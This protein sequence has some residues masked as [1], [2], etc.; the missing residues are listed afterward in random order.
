MSTVMK[1][2][3]ILA[4]KGPAVVTVKPTETI[5]ALSQRLREKRIGAAVV[6]S[7]GRVFE[8]VISERDI[9]YAVSAHKANLHSMQVSALMTKAVI[10][11]SPEDTVA[12]VAS[13]M[14]SRNIRHLPV[15]QDKRLIGVISM[16]DVLNLR[17][18]ELQRQASML[19]AFAS[20]TDI[21]PQDR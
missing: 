12:Q 1:V 16:R 3:D 4:R 7:D 21:T 15:E 19:R 9:A 18:D 8:G 13:T 11:C 20:S 14:L 5:A 10:T 17:L 6:S 2:S